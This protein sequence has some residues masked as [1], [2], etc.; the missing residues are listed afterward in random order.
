VKKIWVQIH[1]WLGLASGLVVFIISM[2]GCIYVFEDELKAWIY[3]DR[4]TII[5]PENGTKM[6]LTALLSAAQQAAGAEHTITNITLFADAHHTYRFR[7]ERIQDTHGLTHFSEIVYQHQFYV[8]PYTGAIVKDENT[9]L[10]FFA[11]VL[12]LHRN[13]LLNREVGKLIIG[14]SVILF[15]ILLLTGLILWWPKNKKA[16][17]Q[18]FAFRWKT[19]TKWKRKNYDLHNILG[20]YSL[21]I[22]L[23]ISLTG[24]V[25]AFKWFDNGVQWIANGGKQTERP[26]RISSDTTQIGA[27]LPLD[28]IWAQAALLAPGATS[29]NIKLP[30]KPLDVVSVTSY[31]PIGKHYDRTNH[32]FDQYT[33]THL[34]SSSFDEMDT[35]AKLKAM[36]YDI[37]VGNILSLPGKVLA[38]LAAM[39]SASLPITGLMIWLGKRNKQK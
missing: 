18:R 16:S 30:N 29:F 34:S 10:E 9:K 31:S 7:P 13:L 24:L 8:D 17:K 5:A 4:E 28:S 36:N 14:S 11:V 37:H 19:T 6:P 20:F 22:L 2:T 3:R 27:D 32:H 26:A 38:F 15:V 1:L 25:F 33:G 21:A 12:R 39:I 23:V 35:G